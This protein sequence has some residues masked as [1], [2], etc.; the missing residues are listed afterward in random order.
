MLVLGAGPGPLLLVEDLVR[1]DSYTSTDPSGL[2]SPQPGSWGLVCFE[3]SS[4]WLSGKSLKSCLPH[5]LGEKD[6]GLNSAPPTSVFMEGGAAAL[7]PVR[8]VWS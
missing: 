2:G 5:L 8:A 1:R 7:T 4:L 6:E 3:D